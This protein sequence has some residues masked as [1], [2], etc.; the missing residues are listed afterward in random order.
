MTGSDKVIVAQCGE[1]MTVLVEGHLKVANNLVG[2]SS[3]VDHQV[4]KAR[5]VIQTRRKIP[6]GMTEHQQGGE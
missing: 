5:I 6:I 3:K 4:Y 2:P 1:V